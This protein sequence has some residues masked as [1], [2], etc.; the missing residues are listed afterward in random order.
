[1]VSDKERE[2]EQ[3]RWWQIRRE[4]ASGKC[5]RGNVLNSIGVAW[6]RERGG[7]GWGEGQRHA[8]KKIVLKRF[9][10]AK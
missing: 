5:F 3:G 9:Y 10:E 2:R 4:R 8:V 6:E 1:M 7:G